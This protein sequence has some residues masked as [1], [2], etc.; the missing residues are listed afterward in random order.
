M[1]AN[2][3]D[4]GATSGLATNSSPSDSIT[5]ILGLLLNVPYQIVDRHRSLKPLEPGDTITFVDGQPL[6]VSPYL[7]LG[8]AEDR[9]CGFDFDDMH[10]DG[11][12]H[13]HIWGTRLSNRGD[14]QVRMKLIELKPSD[15]VASRALIREALGHLG[16]E[17][18]IGLDER[19]EIKEGELAR[20]LV[21]LLAG[22][23][24]SVEVDTGFYADSVEAITL[25]YE[26]GT[27]RT[28]YVQNFDFDRS[29]LTV[30]GKN[31]FD[32][33]DD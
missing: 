28:V 5:T 6:I 18:W 31:F 29:R 20:E 32:D 9:T 30:D 24:I 10:I 15:P 7:N 4:G 21:S 3:V 27:K 14:R 8:A 33:E 19:R 16:I 22:R 17:P 25:A 11:S 1:D 26:D 2:T 12:G 23:V 13:I